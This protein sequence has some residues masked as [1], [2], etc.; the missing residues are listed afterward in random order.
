MSHTPG[1]WTLEFDTD[2]EGMI[3]RDANGDL[4][5]NNADLALI[6]GTPELLD[7]L[8][9]WQWA[10]VNDDIEELQNARNSRDV[11]IAKAKGEDEKLSDEDAAY[12]LPN[13]D[14]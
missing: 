8:M 6:S 3:V 1:P 11:A 13:E 2:F 7:A 9:Q 10:E 4:I 5:K 14:L 12:I